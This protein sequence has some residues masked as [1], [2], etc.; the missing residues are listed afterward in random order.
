MAWIAVNKNGDEV[1]YQSKPY[2]LV[3][4]FQ[5]DYEEFIFVPN[6]TSL[7]LTGKQM[8]FDDEPI[9]LS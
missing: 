5:T 9:K 7:K 4:E 2:K 3:E 8:S 1:I 6:G